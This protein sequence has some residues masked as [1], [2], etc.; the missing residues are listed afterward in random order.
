MNKKGPSPRNG[1]HLG[2]SH[3]WQHVFSR[4]ELMKVAAGTAGLGLI[5]GLGAPKLARARANSGEPVPIPGG[6]SP[7][8]ILIHHFPLPPAGTPLSSINEPSEITDFNGFIGDTSI[9]GAG[10]GTGFATPLAFKTDMGFMQGEFV[11]VD[12]EH[13]QGTF[14]FI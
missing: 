8:G 3:I 5:S 9:R 6:V 4:R 12:G 1:L 7:F 11:G 14:V 13:H 2:H 10:F